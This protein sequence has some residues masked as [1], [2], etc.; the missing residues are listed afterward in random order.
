MGGRLL[1][2]NTAVETAGLAA[3]AGED[4][5]WFWTGGEECVVLMRANYS[6]SFLD[7]VMLVPV[8]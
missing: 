6:G 3:G 7:F 1:N 2:I 5:L 4:A 8:H